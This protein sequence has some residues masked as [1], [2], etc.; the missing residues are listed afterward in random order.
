LENAIPLRSRVRLVCAAGELGGEVRYCVFRELGYF[1]GIRFDEGTK[2]TR[3]A[4]K[5]Q[6]LF[7]PDRLDPDR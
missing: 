3:R 4:F 6:H 2:W 1:L 5:P 7:D